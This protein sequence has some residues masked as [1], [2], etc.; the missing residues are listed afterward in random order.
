MSGASA[1]TLHAPQD[2][3]AESERGAATDTT[4]R[5][6]PERP[7]GAE[8]RAGGG[9]GAGV[10]KPATILVVDDAPGNRYAV[11][12]ILRGAG[13]RV[14]EAENGCETLRLMEL[15]PDLVVLDIRLPDSTGYEVCRSIKSNP[16]TAFTPV[17]HLSASYTADT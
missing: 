4:E 10:S 7:L 11:S 13:M 2:E 15:A 1:S 6:A 14:I 17:M 3:R 5:V 9:A 16:A 12:R 8:D